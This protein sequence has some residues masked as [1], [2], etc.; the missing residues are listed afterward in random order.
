MNISSCLASRGLPPAARRYRVCV[1]MH[2]LGNEAQ[3]H[4]PALPPPIAPGGIS[5]RAL[6]PLLC[7]LTI[8]VRPLM[9]SELIEHRGAGGVSRWRGAS[10]IFLR[11]KR[12]ST[13]TERSRN[14]GH[15]SLL[16]ILCRLHGEQTWIM[17]GLVRFISDSHF[18]ITIMQHV[19]TQTNF[20]VS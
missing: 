6:L 14:V 11:G 3:H 4:P 18:L 5:S 15:K 13:L 10:A 20:C 17:N 12:R 8:S 19:H 2:R 9:H 7:R 16:H 1:L